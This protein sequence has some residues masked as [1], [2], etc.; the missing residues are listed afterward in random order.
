MTTGALRDCVF[1]VADSTMAQVFQ[2][3]LMKNRFH[4]GLGCRSFRFDPKEDLFAHTG[5]NDPGLYT[6]AHQLVAPFARTHRYA[7]VALDAAWEGSPGSKQIVECVSAKLMPIW[8]VGRFC[9]IVIDPELEAWVLQDSPHVAAAFR[10]D[11]ALPLRHWLRDNG[12]WP[13]EAIKPPD[14]KTAVEAVCRFTRTA[15][16]AAVYGKIV[17]RVSVTRCVDPAFR[18]LAETLCEWFPSEAE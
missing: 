5:G 12:H 1:W 10:Y 2:A 16:S 17:S 11:G 18:R 3:F 15:R 7:V 14:P 9:V 6:R 13:A 8:P 4:L